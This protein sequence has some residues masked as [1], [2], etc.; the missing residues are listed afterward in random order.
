MNDT[1]NDTQQQL[2]G[3]AKE[4]RAEALAK[5]AEADTLSRKATDFCKTAIV[6]YITVALREFAPAEKYQIVEGIKEWLEE[7]P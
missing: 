6:D 2:L 3:R 4:L 1:L 5:Q 7:Q